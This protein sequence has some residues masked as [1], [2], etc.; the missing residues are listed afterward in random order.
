M[1]VRINCI[2]ASMFIFINTHK[3]W[4][5]YN[6]HS[7]L[8]ICNLSVLMHPNPPLTQTHTYFVNISSHT[9]THICIQM[10][11]SPAH[12]GCPFSK[13]AK[14]SL[15]RKWA[16]SWVKSTHT[17]THWQLNFLLHKCFSLHIHCVSVPSCLL[18]CVG[19]RSFFQIRWCWRRQWSSPLYH[20][21][22]DSIYFS[23][24]RLYFVRGARFKLGQ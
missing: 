1:Y 5:T 3:Q 10:H 9:D 20:P 17:H 8:Y 16:S 14:L 18:P 21:P 6:F 15:Y 19:G 12:T 22:F 11:C 4:H 2:F 23:V 24:S 13:Q 7:Y